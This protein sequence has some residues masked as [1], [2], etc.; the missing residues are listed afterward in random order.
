[1]FISLCFLFIF[2]PSSICAMGINTKGNNIVWKAEDVS[3]R[4]LQKMINTSD[5][6][7]LDVNI[8][9][10]AHTL[11]LKSYS[12]NRLIKNIAIYLKDLAH[13]S[14]F[15]VTTILNGNTRPHTKRDSF[16]CRFDLEM[17]LINSSYCRQ[18]AMALSTNKTISDELQQKINVLN[19][20]SK[21][22]DKNVSI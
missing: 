20:E 17:K 4:E 15:F 8:S 22:L 3:L 19:K 16:C 1:M 7:R 12:H 14:S 10:V 11:A 13:I 18:Y 9:N 21:K 2:L 6:I 5:S